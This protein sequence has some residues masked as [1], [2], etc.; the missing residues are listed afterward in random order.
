MASS[1][2][3]GAPSGAPSG[4]PS[5]D[6]GDLLNTGAGQATTAPRMSNA[7]ARSLGLVPPKETRTRT[8][9]A[10]A[11]LIQGPRATS[12]TDGRN[13]PQMSYSLPAQLP[14]PDQHMHEVYLAAQAAAAGNTTQGSLSQ[15]TQRQASLGMPPSIGSAAIAMS[16]GLS[17]TARQASL[18]LPQ[19]P[20]TIGSATRQSSLGLPQSQGSLGLAQSGSLG[21]AQRQGSLGLP[22]GMGQGS[23]GMAQGVMG[24]GS[25]SVSYEPSPQDLQ[26]WQLGLQQGIQGAQASQKGSG[27]L[28]GAAGQAQTALVMEQLQRLGL[29]TDG[30]GNLNPGQLQGLMT[31]LS[32]QGLPQKYG[33]TP[34]SLAGQTIPEA[35]QVSGVSM[36]DH[37][38]ATLMNSFQ[39]M[40]V[41]STQQPKK[42]QPEHQ[43]QGGV[44]QIATPFASPEHAPP[45]DFFEGGDSKAV[46]GMTKRSQ[47]SAQLG[48][49]SGRVAS[50]ET[51]SS[52]GPPPA[53]S[54][55]RASHSPFASPGQQMHKM[56]STSSG[57]SVPGR[58]PSDHTSQNAS[59]QASSPLP[60]PHRSA[61][62]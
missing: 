42:A 24:Q 52:L 39:S 50:T 30:G 34:S 15:T 3:S 1:A 12:L 56:S 49:L 9:G 51:S 46:G 38:L 13:R 48:Q 14:D 25:G 19:G 21:A 59:R 35:E 54:A 20:G 33:H 7:M 55:S 4:T 60:S 18:G 37:A 10:L 8:L 62:N 43:P 26:A 2:R 5:A 57:G 11:G 41:T 53:T 45:L 23:G 28:D 17:Q 44:G 29:F 32:K 27:Q 47:G 16:S 40:G 36:D 6:L 58:S 22:Q 31:M 61:G